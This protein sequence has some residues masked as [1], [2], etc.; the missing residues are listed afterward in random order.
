MRVLI[1]A[2]EVWNDTIFG[3][4]VLTNWFT[5]FPAEFAEIYCSPGLP[6]NKVCKRYFQITDQQMFQSLFGRYTAGEEVFLEEI[7]DNKMRSMHQGVYK[8]LKKLSHCLHT[9]MMM[10]RDFIWLNGRYNK[11][12]LSNFIREFNP[13]VVF[14]PRLSTPK[15]MRLERYVHSITTAPFIAFTGDDEA[16]FRQYSLSPLYWLRRWYINRMFRETVPIYSHYFMHSKQQAIEYHKKYG[17]NTEILFKSSNLD[18]VVPK[19]K[20]NSPLI[21]V[22]AGRLYCNRWKTLG[23]IGK[24]MK[25]INKKGDRIVLHVYTTDNLSRKQTEVLSPNNSIYIKGAVSPAELKSIYSEADLALHV[26]SFDR[27]YRLGTRVSFSTKIIDLL[28]SGCPVMAV[29][30]QEQ[31][32]FAYLKEQDAAFC[33]SSY[34]EIQP[35]LELIV[36]KPELLKK[37]SIKAQECVLRNHSKPK[38]QQQLMESFGKYSKV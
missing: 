5:D 33:A 36:N 11:D 34:S 24:A 17:L 28:S 16:S 8:H 30:W 3:N 31:T 20:L 4:G 22:Y 29:C 37:Y 35:I 9:P 12:K 2:D 18:A 10:V 25:E 19:N 6:N 27:K 38:V 32:G 7:G 14:C 26:E 13:D 1:I 23:A 21:V 15:L